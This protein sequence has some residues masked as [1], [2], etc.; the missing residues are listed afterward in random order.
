ML[1]PVYGFSDAAIRNLVVILAVGLFI[2][3]A[4]SWAFEW[5]PKGIVKDSGEDPSTPAAV[6]GNKRIDR[7]II[8]ILVVG[9]AFFSVDKFVLDPARDA[10]NIEAATEKGR[11]DALLKV[12]S[13]KSVAV[14]PFVSRSTLG[15]DVYF[16]DGI[17]DDILTALARIASL[18]VTSR[19]SVEQYRGTS[20]TMR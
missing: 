20:Q 15:D 12:L 2:T 18:V 5:T 9:V 7:F 11:A 16:V 17:H 10:Q 4:L 14:L 1:L 19:T 13:D 8:F 6:E 3:L